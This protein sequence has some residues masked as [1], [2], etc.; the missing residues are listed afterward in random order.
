MYFAGQTWLWMSIIDSC[1]ATLEDVLE[2]IV[3]ALFWQVL[4]RFAPSSV[5][6][7]QIIVS[8]GSDILI[9]MVS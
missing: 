3:E 8:I 9:P 5:E 2:R 7:D 6:V 1:Q 4:D